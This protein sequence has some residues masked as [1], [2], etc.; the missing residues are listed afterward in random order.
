MQ[1]K[2]YTKTQAGLILQFGLVVFSSL[3]FWIPRENYILLLLNIGILAFFYQQIWKQKFSVNPLMYGLIFC[4]AMFAPTNLSQDVYRFIWDG[5]LILNGYNPH[6]FRP[7]ELINQM[8]FSTGNWRELYRGMGP[9]SQ[10]NY[11]CYPLVTQIYSFIAAIIPIFWVQLLVMKLLFIGT[12]ILTI[13]STRKLLEFCKLEKHYLHLFWLNPLVL[14]EGLG[15]LHFEWVMLC[16]VASG[17]YFL[18][19]INYLNASIFITLAI[20]AKLIPFLMLPFFVRNLGWKKSIFFGLSVVVLFF[21]SSLI[22]INPS[23]LGNFLESIKLYYGRFEFNSPI[24]A[25]YLDYGF[26]KYGFHPIGSYA[27]R[28]AFYG[29][30]ALLTFCFY[31]LKQNEDWKVFF[32]RMAWAT[33]IYYFFATTIHPWYLIFP[34]FFGIL[35]QNKLTIYWSFLV[36]LSYLFYDLKLKEMYDWIRIVEYALLL[37]FSFSFLKSEWRNF[38]IN[39]FS[40]SN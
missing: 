15:N 9:L 13:Q 21:I 1:A 12:F 32:S 38:K 40:T 2:K 30:L 4:S 16:F 3:V 23:N 20:Q 26:W 11:S 17:I 33:T 19:Q 6:D 27:R 22:F 34:L 37:I 7:K 39:Y 28:L 10:G 36:F 14:I 24:F 35:S 18:T 31:R 5:K 25:F 8:G 29:F